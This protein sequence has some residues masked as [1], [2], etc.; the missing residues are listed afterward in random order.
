MK[1]S[2]GRSRSRRSPSQT[3]V[4]PQRPKQLVFERLEPRDMLAA[5]VAEPPVDAFP[6]FTSEV[7]QAPED[8]AWEA[9]V[10]DQSEEHVGLPEG[11][12]ISLSPELAWCWFAPPQVAEPPAIY[13]GVDE[14]VLEGSAELELTEFSPLLW[15]IAPPEPD[16]DVAP[17]AEQE[18][19]PTDLPPVDEQGKIEPTII[20]CPGV[21]LPPVCPEIDPKLERSGV[22]DEYAKFLGDN[23]TWLEDHGAGGIQAQ[24]VTP[25]GQLPW[26]ELPTPGEAGAFDAWY[27]EVYLGKVPVD[28]WGSSV[29]GGL[30]T[31]DEDD[32]VTLSEGDDGDLPVDEEFVPPEM[33]K[34]F[35]SGEPVSLA[36]ES[37][38]LSSRD[39]SPRARTLSSASDNAQTAVTGNRRPTW[40]AALGPSGFGDATESG[41]PAKGKRRVR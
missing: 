18:P 32:P 29:D 19:E 34:D 1:S 4:A 33:V 41:T 35:G 37:Q 16:S 17:E 7:E 20:V 8:S 11:F 30:D 27:T 12:S 28:D 21:E 26:I 31:S 3:A 38:W 24:V 36:V 15:C 22:L 23:P 9:T 13:D 25:S 5:L 14:G 6:E 2:A 40:M 39:F 10:T